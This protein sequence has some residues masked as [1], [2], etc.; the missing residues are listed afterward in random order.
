MMITEKV[1]QISEIA[2]DALKGLSSNPKYLLPK[3]FY[4]EK[5]S[6]I[7]QDIMQM[8][9]YYLTN[10]EL[11]IFHSCKKNI[12]ASF[13][14]GN[15]PFDLIELGS[16]DGL[17]TKILLQELMDQS[18]KFKY[19]PVD[20]SIKANEELVSQ[21]AVEMPDLTVEAKTGDY[22]QVLKEL[23]QTSFNRKVIFFLGSNIGNFSKKEITL[24]FN[25]LSDLTNKDDKLFIGFDLKKSPEIIM[26]A[27]SDPYGHTRDFNLNHL[28][29]LNDDLG[30][31]FELN[32]FEHHTDY[33][34]ITGSVK[35]YLVSKIEQTIFV[36]ALEKFFHFM[37]W[38]PILMELSQ[39]YDLGRILA[40]AAENGFEVEHNYA[41]Q[42]NYFVDSLWTKL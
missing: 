16:G 19:I 4:D 5:G 11:E 13:D 23:N 37:Q 15:S 32:N 27:Y 39:K 2:Q 1:T 7:F 3:Y 9:E 21:L 36:S 20:I 12:S 38:E 10:C 24:F 25:R 29:R 34:P 28:A 33:N 40:L 41:D 18:A 26:K 17:K 30:A 22:F 42:R 31:N 35:S 6:K 14:V 8:P